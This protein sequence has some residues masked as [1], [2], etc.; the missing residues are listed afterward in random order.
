MKP[1]LTAP[2]RVIGFQLTPDEF[3]T[4][5]TKHFLYAVLL[6]WLAG[7]GR[8]WDNPRAGFWQHLGLGSVAY[9]FALGLYLYLI[10]WP[11]KPANWNFT[12]LVT[13]LA[14]T[15]PLAFLYALPVERWMPRKDAASLNGWFLFTVALWR[16]IIYGRFLSRV[17]GFD[18]MRYFIA[19]LL[20]PASI[21][22]GLAALN[23]EHAVFQLMGG[24]REVDRTSADSSYEVVLMLSYL[25]LLT[26]PFLVLLYICAIVS[27]RSTTKSSSAIEDPTS[28]N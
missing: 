18:T 26:S 2:L 14:F 9:V 22:A 19:L 11:L 3:N 5:G 20:P 7:I 25:S 6:A 24:L 12:R 8:Y 13:M 1:L 23:L 10:L 27:A 15:S 16:V 28:K 21:V 4:W 17:A